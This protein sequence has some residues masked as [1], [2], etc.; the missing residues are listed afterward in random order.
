MSLCK[1]VCSDYVQTCTVPQQIPNLIDRAIGIAITENAPTCVIFPSD[2]LDLPYEPPA[3]AF[4]QVPSSLGLAQATPTPDPGA[5]RAA[6]NLLNAGGKVAMLVGQ[7]ARGCLAELTEV[8]DILGA[9][10]AKALLGKDV[11]PDTLP[12]V[13]GSIGLLGTTASYELMTGCDTLLT[14]GSNFPY[15]QFLPEL[16][17]AIGGAPRSGAR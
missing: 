14:V 13:T 12:W 6:A 17:Q 11:L 7:G 8:A 10:V 4:K 2:V 9:G 3:H 1:D 16:G 5:V 15:T